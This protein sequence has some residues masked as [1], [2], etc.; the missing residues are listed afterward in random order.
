VN[1]PVLFSILSSHVCIQSVDVLELLSRNV[2]V[3]VSVECENDE[4]FNLHLKSR[5]RLLLVGSALE[6]A[7][8]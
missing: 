4:T 1:V 8:I 3:H 6:E 7:K 2:T 5:L